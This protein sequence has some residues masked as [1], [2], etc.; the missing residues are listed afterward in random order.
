MLPIIQTNQRLGLVIDYP[1]LLVDPRGLVQNYNNARRLPFYCGFTCFTLIC[2]IC[3]VTSINGLLPQSASFP[4]KSTFNWTRHPS[5]RQ[6]RNVPWLFDF[7]ARGLN[8]FWYLKGG[9][10]FKTGRMIGTGYL[11]LFWETAERESKLLFS[12]DW[13]SKQTCCLALLDRLAKQSSQNFETG[14]FVWRNNALPVAERKTKTKTFFLSW[15]FQ[16]AA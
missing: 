15:G 5:L 1:N 8:Y 2:L 9:R 12:F 13:G 6:I 10:L 7:S 16:W 11:F 14:S 3:W 4:F